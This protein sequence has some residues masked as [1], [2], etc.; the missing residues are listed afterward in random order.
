MNLRDIDWNQALGTALLATLGVSIVGSIAGAYGYKKA[1]EEIAY[2]K[3]QV[4][5]LSP[6]LSKMG[7]KLA[8]LP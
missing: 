6:L 2:Y 8:S 5:P 3:K 1:Q 4:E 7:V